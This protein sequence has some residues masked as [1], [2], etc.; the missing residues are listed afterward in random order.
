MIATREQLWR[1]DSESFYNAIVSL[2]DC[3]MPTIAAVP[4]P[5]IAGGVGLALACDIVIAA[6]SASFA[7]PEPKRGIVAAM[8]CPL[9][10]RRTSQARAG[11]VLLGG[12]S[13]AAKQAAAMGL[14]EVV[15]ADAEFDAVV[16]A[17]VNSILECSPH[18]LS[19][20][21]HFLNSVGHDELRNS[22][23]RSIQV[24]A[25]ARSSEDAREGLDRVLGKTETDLGHGGR[26]HMISI[27]LSTKTA[28]ITGAM[29][30]TRANDCVN[31]FISA[32]ANVVVNYLD[33]EGAT[34]RRDAETAG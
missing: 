9:L 29:P 21:K 8:V 17:Q 19:T 33:D 7:V 32:G 3:R 31:H 26:R 16:Q 5:A 10:L 12:Q 25:D 13:I 11:F 28:F 2:L 6:E 1:Q 4:G 22:L 18:A 20:T 27:D 30:R 24:S 23:A 15:A 14:C 34:N